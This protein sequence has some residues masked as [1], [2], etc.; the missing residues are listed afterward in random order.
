[1]AKEVGLSLRSLQSIEGGKSPVRKMHMLAAERVAIKIAIERQNPGLLIDE[2][3]WR[4]LQSL[5]LAV[6]ALRGDPAP[7]E[8]GYASRLRSDVDPFTVLKHLMDSSAKG[9]RHSS[10]SA[11]LARTA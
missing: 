6:W 1:M 11:K 4:D 10:D 9:G 8:P 7:L 5:A 2:A 3:F